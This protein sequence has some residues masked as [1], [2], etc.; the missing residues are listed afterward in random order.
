M[1]KF[2]KNLEQCNRKLVT[3][4]DPHLG[5]NSGKKKIVEDEIKLTEPKIELEYKIHETEQK[6]ED[7]NYHITEQLL[8]EGI[9]FY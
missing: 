3:I 5:I 8:K 6:E 2:V 9:I 4:I 7:D 1:E